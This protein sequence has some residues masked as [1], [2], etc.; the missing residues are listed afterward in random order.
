MT[1]APCPETVE[2]LVMAGMSG[3]SI[4][5]GQG[6]GDPL[7]SAYCTMETGQICDKDLK[8]EKQR[9]LWTKVGKWKAQDRQ[10][11]SPTIANRRSTWVTKIRCLQ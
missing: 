5:T 11:P 10:H 2:R 6:V 4:L 3:G 9:M 8:I 1:R 7:M